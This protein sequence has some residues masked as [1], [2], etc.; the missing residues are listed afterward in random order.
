VNN[1]VLSRAA[2]LAFACWRVQDPLNVLVTWKETRVNNGIETSN[3]KTSLGTCVLSFSLTSL[4]FTRRSFG[5]DERAHIE[6]CCNLCCFRIVAIPPPTST[7]KSEHTPPVV[8]DQLGNS[9]PASCSSS[10]NGQ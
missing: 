9:E 2:N 1:D 8:D 6:S 5:K 3:L 7:S 4:D 10:E